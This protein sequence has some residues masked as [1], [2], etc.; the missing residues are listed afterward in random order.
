M[1]FGNGA[2]TNVMLSKLKAGIKKNGV[3]FIAV[4][5]DESGELNIR[6]FK[7]KLY[8]ITEAQLNMLPLGERKKV[9]EQTNPNPEK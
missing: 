6:A 8:I 2:L 4:V 7:N 3:K 9:I 1:I 5:P